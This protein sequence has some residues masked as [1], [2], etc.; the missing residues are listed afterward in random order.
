MTQQELIIKHL[1]EDQ[2]HI[3]SCTLDKKEQYS[4]DSWDV[5][6]LE[7]IIEDEPCWYE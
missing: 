5:D 2:N 1:T 4:F 3:R 7:E 6:M